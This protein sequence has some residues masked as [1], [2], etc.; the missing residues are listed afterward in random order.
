MVITGRR[1]TENKFS[2]PPRLE[3]DIRRIEVGK[4]DRLKDAQDR[5]RRR[6]AQ[7]WAQQFLLAATF[8][9]LI[10]G[11]THA[12]V[13]QSDSE[14]IAELERKLEQS[15]QTIEEMAA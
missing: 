2:S 6:K 15:Q 10:Y 5:S 7:N 4:R 13:A 11:P 8:T 14:R 12:A 1:I 9:V 3:S